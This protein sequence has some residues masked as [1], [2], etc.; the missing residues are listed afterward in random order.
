MFLFYKVL[1]NLPKEPDGSFR[2]ECRVTNCGGLWRGVG[3]SQDVELSMLKP[4][5]SLAKPIAWNGH[6]AEWFAQGFTEQIMSQPEAKLQTLDLQS[7]TPSL[8]LGT[9]HADTEIDT[10]SWVTG[11]VNRF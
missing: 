9:S 7:R 1:C 5:K 4:G 6:L 8:P 10:G 11:L 2:V 3:D